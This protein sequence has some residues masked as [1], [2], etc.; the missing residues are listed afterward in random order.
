MFRKEKKK[1]IYCVVPENTH[2]PS[3]EGFFGSNPPT[4][5]EVPVKPHTVL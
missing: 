2:T 4:P 3:T 5:L 1:K